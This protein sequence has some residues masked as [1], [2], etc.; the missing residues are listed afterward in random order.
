MQQANSGALPN[1]Y[2]ASW[3]KTTGFVPADLNTPTTEGNPNSPYVYNYG[4]VAGNNAGTIVWSDYYNNGHV[5]SSSTGDTRAVRA[6][7]Q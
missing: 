3:S 4:P 1:E 6:V 7:G 2:L 5:W